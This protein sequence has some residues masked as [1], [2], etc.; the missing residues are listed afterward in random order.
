MQL[1]CL[2]ILELLLLY[3]NPYKFYKKHMTVGRNRAIGENESLKDD[4]LIPR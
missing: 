2:A 1:F 3:N 4:Y